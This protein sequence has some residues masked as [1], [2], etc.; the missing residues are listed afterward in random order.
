MSLFSGKGVSG[1]V[2]AGR[3]EGHDCGNVGDNFRLR[4]DIEA[5]S[6]ETGV[7]NSVIVMK[8]NL[9]V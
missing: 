4:D 1:S 8:S 9:K 3:A 6:V 5:G 7:Y 2:K